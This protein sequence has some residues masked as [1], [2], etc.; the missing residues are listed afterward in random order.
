MKKIN[1]G[2]GIFLKKMHLL[3]GVYG[4]KA[5]HL[6]LDNEQAHS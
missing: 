3:L 4:F 5:D 1:K 6:G 2:N